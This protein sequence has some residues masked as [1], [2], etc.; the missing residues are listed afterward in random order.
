[1]G[2]GPI[3]VLLIED[4]EDDYIL[5]RDR[6]AEVSGTRYDLDWVTEFDAA[7]AAIGRR[8][9]DVYL[10]DYRLGGRSGLDLLRRAIDEGCKGP[11]ILLTGQGDRAVDVQAMAVGAADFLVKAGMDGA[12]L[13]RSIRYA[14]ER[15]RTEESLLQARAELEDRVLERTAALAEANESL[16]NRVAELD[17]AREMAETASRAKDQFLAMLSHELRTP[18]T[19]VLMTASSMQADPDVPEPCREAFAEIRRNVELEAR[20]IDD[21]L[22]VMRIIRGKLPYY[23]EVVDAHD[24]VGRALQ[25]CRGEAETKRID[26][27]VDLRAAEHHVRADPARLQ[28]VFW[29]LLKNAIKFTPEGGRIAVRSRDRAGGLRIEVVDSGIGIS[30]GTLAKVFNAFEQGEDSITRRFGGLGLGLAIS[31]SIAEAHGGSLSATSEGAGHGAT[32]TLE[33]GT[34]ADSDRAAAPA[35][36]PSSVEVGSLQGLRVLLVEDDALTARVMAKLMRQNGYEVSTATTLARAL[37]TPIDHVDLLI[38]DIGLP[39]GSGLD[40]MRQ[41]KARRDLPA[42]ALTG[43]GTEDDVLKAQEAGFIAHLT[44]PLD[45]DKLDAMIR[46]VARPPGLAQASA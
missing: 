40:L 2:A 24:L 25:I 28:Q 30:P 5:T 42:I 22:D 39:D 36:D 38:S 15:K 1:M 45:F 19:P 31:Q 11:L 46:R 20:L 14:I 12:M 8:E 21:L 35:D 37:E 27:V 41:I 13:E 10:L 34:V 33:I 4:D 26:L 16:R 44:K 17:A 29:N 18:L 43:Y 32:F 23:L 9:H 3:R 6:L 7:L